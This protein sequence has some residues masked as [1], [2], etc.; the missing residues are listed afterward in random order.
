MSDV[1]SPG[2][3]LENVETDLDEYGFFCVDMQLWWDRLS[4]RSLTAKAK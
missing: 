4:V 3:I 1:M 2:D